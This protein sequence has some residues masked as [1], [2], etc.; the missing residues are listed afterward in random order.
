VHYDFRTPEYATYPEIR[1]VKWECCRGL[2]RSFGYNRM[3]EDEHHISVPDLVHSFVD[4][5]S[6]NG[7]LLLNVGPMADGTIPAPQLDRLSGLG[8][9]LAV[10]GEA[11]YGTR[12]WTR[13]EGTTASDIPVRFTA[14]PDALYAI[15]LG[16]PQGSEV[17][18]KDLDIDER[19]TIGM[20][21]HKGD[22]SWIREGENVVVSLSGEFG[23]T[24][25]TA[26]RI[27]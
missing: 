5:V 16:A 19:A 14:G 15:L 17:V 22:L 9:W 11:I 24:C 18:L 13:A 20:L 4:I 10:N 7:N 3:E 21:G 1:T 6:K 23:E 27:E 2:G 25:A 26:F 12:P 8:A